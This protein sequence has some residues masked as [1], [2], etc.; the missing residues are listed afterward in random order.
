MCTNCLRSSS[1]CCSDQ[2]PEILVS[3]YIHSGLTKS[4]SQ[5]I[6][7]RFSPAINSHFVFHREPV[8]LE[9]NFNEPILM[10]DSGANFTH[11]S[12]KYMPGVILTESF[13]PNLLNNQNAKI[14]ANL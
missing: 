12:Y 9:T 7:D 5:I 6:P 3:T 13:I 4:V 14:S 8:R 1:H 10:F 11:S 2:F